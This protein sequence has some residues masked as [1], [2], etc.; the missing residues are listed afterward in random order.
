MNL[1]KAKKLRHIVSMF[2]QYDQNV[3]YVT[4]RKGTIH[5]QAETKRGI[6]LRLKKAV[7]K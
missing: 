6:Y 3:A 5:V 1:K 7:K 2:Q 4:D